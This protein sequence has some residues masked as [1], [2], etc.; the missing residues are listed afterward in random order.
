MR[1]IYRHATGMWVINLYINN[2]MCK[3]LPRVRFEQD[4]GVGGVPTTSRHHTP[5]PVARAPEH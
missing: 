3:V 4:D 5:H 1:N 2:V